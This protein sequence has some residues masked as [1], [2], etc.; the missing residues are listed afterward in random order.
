MS[1][2]ATPPFTPEIE[3]HGHIRKINPSARSETLNTKR[4]LFT[5]L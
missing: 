5:P 1:V 4:Q 3:D 2:A